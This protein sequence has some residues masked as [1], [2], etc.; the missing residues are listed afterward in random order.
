[1]SMKTKIR[2][3]KRITIRGKIKDVS[4]KRRY[5]NALSKPTVQDS[6]PGRGDVLIHTNGNAYCVFA[7]SYTN[8]VAERRLYLVISTD[9]GFTWSSRIGLTTG[10]WDNAPSIIQHDLTSTTSAIDMVFLRGS[11]NVIYRMAFDVNGSV[12]Y[13]PATITSAPLVGAHPQLIKTLAGKFRLMYLNSYASYTIQTYEATTFNQATSWTSISGVYFGGSL[14]LTK[15]VTSLCVRRHV[16]SGHLFALVTYATAING[17]TNAVF[18]T[19]ETNWALALGISISTDEGLSWSVIQPMTTQTWDASFDLVPHS[20]PISAD[21]TELAD[22]SIGIL[23]QEGTV[24]Q[25]IN[26]Y[27]TPATDDYAGSYVYISHTN[28][29]YDSLRDTLIIA[30]DGYYENGLPSGG[31]RFHTRNISGA[32]NSAFEINVH[33]TPPIWSHLINSME[34]SPDYRYLAVTSDKGLSI[35]DMSNA[36]HSLWT[37]TEYRK[38]TE[39]L[40]LSEAGRDV[41]WL[42]NT[43]LVLSYGADCTDDSWGAKINMETGTFTPMF[44]YNT[45]YGTRYCSSRLIV[46]G[47]YAFS[48]AGAYNITAFNLVTGLSVCDLTISNMINSIAY[49][50]IN[51]EFLVGTNAAIVF[52]QF[53]GSAFVQL[54][55]INITTSNPRSY[56]AATKFL[57]VGDNIVT[58]HSDTSLQFYNPHTKKVL[59]VIH[60]T[61]KTMGLSVSTGSLNAYAP[62]VIDVKGTKWFI[63]GGDGINPGLL[64]D[65][66]DNTGK[67]KYGLFAYD[68]TAKL[69]YEG[70]AQFYD[71]ENP[72]T[73]DAGDYNQ[74]EFPRLAARSD[75]ALIIYS[76]FCDPQKRIQPFAPV[77]TIGWTDGN[78][79]SAKAKL[80]LPTSIY[81]RASIFKQDPKLKMKA[82]I[83]R[84][85]TNVLE[86]K[87]NIRGNSPLSVKGVVSKRATVTLTA[88]G[89][90]QGHPTRTITVR[91]R[92]AYVVNVSIMARLTPKRSLNIKGK[93]I[94]PRTKTVSAKAHIHILG[95][96]TLNVRSRVIKTTTRTLGIQSKVLHGSAWQLKS[97]LSQQQGWPE[98]LIYDDNIATFTFTKL[99]IK[100]KIGEVYL[101]SGSINFRSS[102]YPVKITSLSGKAKLV[103]GQ[104]LG[105][106]ASVEAWRTYIHLPCSYSVQSIVK[107]KLH[108]VFY[109]G[110]VYQTP[111]FTAKARIVR[112]AQKR[113]T[114]HFIVPMPQVTGTLTLDNR[115]SYG[116]IVSTKAFIVRS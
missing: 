67:L 38:S 86:V 14:A 92:L 76:R 115:L 33:T 37:V 44:Y 113:F 29:L 99:L 55:T 42:S 47:D 116:Q 5:I 90:I 4:W 60:A 32:F 36:D 39:P 97:R 45:S 15:I 110:G 104:S 85:F 75:G 19:L 79:F 49:D 20:C 22:G 106:K 1:M 9:G 48:I 111:Q 61:E 64:F 40:M 27:T 108:M 82:F 78:T 16:N 59:G 23:Y 84:A 28:V 101:R 10:Y 57:E 89:R 68:Q 58:T 91:G 2:A 107:K 54:R 95:R 80:L 71:I 52:L 96:P 43:E 65:P 87:A 63:P 100:A 83:W 114:G 77:I 70:D 8:A 18:T 69:L 41:K 3:I 7:D 31:L 50:A 66:L 21:F 34:L 109:I 35:I 105:I 46:N 62:Q 74:M 11:T 12:T 73:I 102:I 24:H 72:R 6:I 26:T 17:S 88:L 30:V 56:S 51:D 81:S 98:P 94:F 93:I 112:R 103:S 25:N 53:T 13:N